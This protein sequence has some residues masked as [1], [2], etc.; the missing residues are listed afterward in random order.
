M[1]LVQQIIQILYSGLSQ[2]AQS[3][4]AGLNSIVTNLFVTG[5]GENQQLSIFAT[6]CAVMAAV[7]LTIGLTRWVVNLIGSFGTRNR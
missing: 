4:G 7:G 6:V 3:F 1:N 2:G 5:T